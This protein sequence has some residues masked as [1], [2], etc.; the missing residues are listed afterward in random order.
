MTQPGGKTYIIENYINTARN[1][2]AASSVDGDSTFWVEVINNVIINHN[3]NNKVG[4]GVYDSQKYYASTFTNNIFFNT[5]I[6]APN[7]DIATNNL[8]EHPL[9]YDAAFI[10]TY[11]DDEGLYYLPIE[12]SNW[13]PNFSRENENSLTSSTSSNVTNSPAAPSYTDISEPSE[14]IVIDE[15]KL[16]KFSSQTKY[17]SAE[18]FSDTS[19]VITGNSWYKLPVQYDVKPNTT[20]SFD[21][22]VI[23]D[24]EIAG[25]ALEINNTQTESAIFRLAG[26]QK[27]GNDVSHLITGDSFTSVT[28]EVGKYGFEDIKYLVFILDNDIDEAKNN[29]EVYFENIRFHTSVYQAPNIVAHDQVLIGI[30]KSD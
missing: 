6:N 8:V 13:V 1:G 21:I 22:K 19:L 14:F 7:L 29:A 18:A 25:I 17:G 30:G 16:S 20:L 3:F 5:Q 28:L 27:Y 23:G 2:I 26:S 9:T 4:L 24:V 15:S 12:S 11:M 10:S